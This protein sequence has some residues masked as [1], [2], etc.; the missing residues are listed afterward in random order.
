MMY[1]LLGPNSYQ[2][3]RKIGEL[4][5]AFYKKSRQ[6][7]GNVLVEEFDGDADEIQPE[8]FYAALEQGNLFSKTRLVI[9]KNVL[10]SNESIFKILKKNGDFIKASRDIFV[11]WEKESVKSTLNFFKKYAEK[12]QEVRPLTKK[13]LA[14]WVDKKA[15]ALGFGL[16]KEECA[17][18]IEEAGPPAGG[19]AEWALE[20][21]LEKRVLGAPASLKSPAGKK[22]DFFGDLKSDFKEAGASPFPFVEKI[23]SASLGWALLALKEAEISGQ[24]LQRLIYPLLWKAKQKRMADAYW[25]GILAES[26]IRR[27]PKNAYEILERFILAIKA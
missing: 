1:L 18:I 24:D 3:L 6:A 10:E 15:K 13:E 25:H 5:S 7:G 17:I 14:A 19:V 2:A 21:E 11:F 20:N 22:S 27:D 23:F 26:A 9:F 4:K 12:I 8:K 16:S